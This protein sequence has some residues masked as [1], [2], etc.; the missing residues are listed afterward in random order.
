MQHDHFLEKMKFDLLIPTPRSRW[1]GV[2]RQNICDHVAAFRDSLYFDKR[3]DCVLNKL[4][5]DLLTIPQGHGG[6]KGLQANYFEIPFNLIFK[7]TMLCK[8]RGGGG[9]RAKHLLPCCCI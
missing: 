5:F 8:M 1:G 6:G 2:F 4:K 7:M 3:H 9:L